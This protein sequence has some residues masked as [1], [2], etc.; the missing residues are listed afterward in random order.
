MD[1]FGKRNSVSGRGF[2]RRLVVVAGLASVA[3]TT[4]ARAEKTAKA[5]T[6]K[7]REQVVVITTPDGLAEASLFYPARKGPW[8]A[9]LLWPDMAG[10]RPLFREMGRKFAAEG[11]VVLVPN[12]FYRSTGP[13][14]GALDPA[15]PNLR[16]ALLKNRDEATDEGIARDAIAYVAFL[17]AQKQTDKGKKIATIGY[18]LGASFAFRTAAAAPERVA[19]VGSIYGVRVAT[20]R[21]NSAHLLVPKTKATYYVAMSR[22]DD[23]REPADKTDI[24]NVIRGANLQGIV[25]I[26]PADHGW[27]VPT[28]K[29]YDTAATE[30]AFSALV[31]LCKDALR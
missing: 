14:G 23:A 2:S 18:D 16:T 12:S 17:D 13:S 20:E 29:T 15:D 1:A 3:F 10:L 6:A 5:K 11:F 8:P 28:G 19:A 7:I 21:S 4:D 27:A 26:Y 30:R 31:K 22:D 9:V 24:A 25:E